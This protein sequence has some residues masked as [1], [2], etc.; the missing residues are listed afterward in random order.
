MLSRFDD[1]LALLDFCNS[2]RTSFDENVKF[3]FRL[4]NWSTLACRDA[5]MAIWEIGHAIHSARENLGRVPS[6]S[7]LADH[8]T[9]RRLEKLFAGRF[10][11]YKELRH[12]SAHYAEM[13]ESEWA[14]A[15]NY[16]VAEG[17]PKDFPAY[18]KRV[19][20]GYQLAG[21][22]IFSS[23]HEKRRVEIEISAATRERLVKT[24]DEVMAA[25]ED[26]WSRYLA[27]VA[28]QPEP[29]D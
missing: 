15:H 16:P 3:Q 14:L 5:C 8:K 2:A 19:A 20:N 7:P 22:R 18:R 1:D 26:V 9:I 10:K 25:Y 28:L 4:G 12:V 29:Q 11:D 17:L 6:L 13:R 24:I 23:V 27:T 21:G